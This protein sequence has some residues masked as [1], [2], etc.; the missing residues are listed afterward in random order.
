LAAL[1]SDG[2]RIDRKMADKLKHLFFFFLVTVAAYAGS[3]LLLAYLNREPAKELPVPA[4]ARSSVENKAGPSSTLQA[5]YSKALAKRSL[6]LEG[7]EDA[8]ER[9]SH[10]QEKPGLTSLNLRLLGTVVNESGSSWAVIQDL[11]TG[12]QVMAMVGSVVAGATVVSIE[13]DRVVLS[14]N[15]RQEILL[16]GVEPARSASGRED[17][18]AREGATS[19]HVLDREVVRENLDNLPSFLM[20][21]RAE[22]Y[23]KEGRPEGFQLSQ[24]QQGSIIRSAGFQDGDV[25]QSVNGQDVRSMEDAIALYQKFGDSDSF[26]IGILRGDTPRT[27]RVVIK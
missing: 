3:T 24:I 23:F 9:T 4:P 11:E 15:G 1:P 16:L 21:A 25:I 12:R 17:Q 20:Q 10:A 22:L 5:D 13:R 6:S 8:S 27:L 18:G 26:T 2:E 19:T 14:V 7:K